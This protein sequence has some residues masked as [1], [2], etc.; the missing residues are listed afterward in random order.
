MATHDWIAPVAASR[1]EDPSFGALS[2]ESIKLDVADADALRRALDGATGIVNCIAGPP[3][4]ILA[5]AQALFAA[6]G[7]VSPRPRVIHIGSLAAY[8]SQ[9]GIV[10]EES[11]LCGDLDEYSAAKAQCDRIAM[12]HDY[13]VSLRPGVVYGPGSPWWSDR[14]ARLLIARRLGDL[15]PHGEGICNLVYVD[16]VAAAVIAALGLRD[17]SQR[18]FNLSSS[19]GLTWNEYFAKYARALSAPSIRTISARRLGLETK[20]FS[21]PLKVLELALRNPHLSRWNRLPPIRPWLP[22]ICARKIQMDASRAESML[23]MD[24]T[25][26]DAGLAITADWFRSGGRTA[27]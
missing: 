8:G 25:P 22:E 4:L 9:T 7:E 26:L 23:G 14:I 20:V 2:V 18:A 21:P 27:I 6:A 19:A 12:Q 3:S 24:W 11:P 1:R 16:D 10:D 5:T 15:G 13:V 17:T